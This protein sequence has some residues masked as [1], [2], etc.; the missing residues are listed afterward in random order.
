M[1]SKPL[2]PNIEDLQSDVIDILQQI[3]SLMNRASTALSSDSSGEKYGKCC[4]HLDFDPRNRCS[5]FCDRLP[6]TPPF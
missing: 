4:L 3:S 1:V 2:K 6:R 5:L